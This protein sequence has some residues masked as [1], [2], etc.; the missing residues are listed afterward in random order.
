ML[1]FRALDTKK[2]QVAACPFYFYI[3]LFEYANSINIFNIC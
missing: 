2:G 1:F 3:A